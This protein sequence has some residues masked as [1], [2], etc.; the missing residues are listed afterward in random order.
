MTAL[1]TALVVGGSAFAGGI[2]IPVVTSG[3]GYSN[4]GIAALHEDGSTLYYNPALASALCHP[5]AG[6]VFGVVDEDCDVKI[7]FAINSYISGAESQAT[8]GHD[9]E[10]IGGWFPIT[11]AYLSTPLCHGFAAGITLSL[12]W[13]LKTSYEGSSKARYL[14]QYSSLTVVDISPVISY[15]VCAGFSVGVGLDI[16]YSDGI[17]SRSIPLLPGYADGRVKVEGDGWTLGWNM[18]ALYCFECGTT[19]GLSYH[20]RVKVCL[21]GKAN[22][23]T[24]GD[25]SEML[26]DTFGLPKEGRARGWVLYPAFVNLSVRHEINDHWAIAGSLQYANWNNVDGVKLRYDYPVSLVLGDTYKLPFVWTDAVMYSIGGS[27]RPNIH[28]KFKAGCTYDQT[29]ECGR[30]SSLFILPTNNTYIYNFGL[31]Y[32]CN[33]NFRIDAT[34]TLAITAQ[35]NISESNTY[36]GTPSDYTAAAEGSADTIIHAFLIQLN[37]EFPPYAL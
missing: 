25:L 29:P 23:D 17:T 32:Y 4:A 20:S 3:A 11:S 15:N 26:G 21:H 27:Y 19:V 37:W 33:P 1:S 24:P 13:G 7:P 8:A 22:Y 30:D 35:A 36:E 9:H 16:I 14:A 10:D 12:P 2:Q 18:G 5:T 31:Q 6:F 28:W 34:Y